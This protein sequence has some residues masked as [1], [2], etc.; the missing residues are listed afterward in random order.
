MRLAGPSPCAHAD[1]GL[2][3]PQLVEALRPPSRPAAGAPC[4]GTSPGPTSWHYNLHPRAGSIMMVI[5]MMISS[6]AR[7]VT[8]PRLTRPS[9]ARTLL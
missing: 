7:T 2:A 4:D 9:Q 1:A 8:Q 5:M 6:P 3:E